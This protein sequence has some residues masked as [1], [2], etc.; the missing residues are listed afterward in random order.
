MLGLSQNQILAIACGSLNFIAGSTAQ[1]TNLLGVNTATY[2]VSAVTLA[3]G[4]VSIILA[5]TTGQGSIVKQ[6]AA[7]P[8]VDK[9]TVNANAN[10]TLAALAVDRN[11]DKVAPMTGAMDKVTEIANGKE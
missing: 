2:V 5:V 6:V 9:I 1:L 8:G 3:A 7:M 4:I 10:Q 11:V